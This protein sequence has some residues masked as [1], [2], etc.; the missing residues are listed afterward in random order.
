MVLRSKEQ[1]V[2]NHHL[3]LTTSGSLKTS[4][5]TIMLFFTLIL[6]FFMEIVWRRE[7]KN[8]FLHKNLLFT[9]E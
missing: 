9:D 1:G 8:V 7:K 6:M 3:F 5:C 2:A 4:F